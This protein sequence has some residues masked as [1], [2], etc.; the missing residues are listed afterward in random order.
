MNYYVNPLLFGEHADPSI[1]LDGDEYFMVF[2]SC[3]GNN[4]L[5]Q[6]WHSENLIEWTPMYYVLESCGLDNAW[7]PE[8][9][10]Y[11]GIYYIYNYA[12]A[13]GCFVT[14]TSD[15]R[16]GKW[17]QPVIIEGV[18]GIDPGHVIDR[19][20]KRYLI[21]SRNYLYPLS[22]NGLRIIG[23]G[24][25]ICDEWKIPD[26]IDVEGSCAESPKFFYKDGYYYLTIA[27][28]GT[29]GPATSHGSISYRAKELYGPY[30]MSPYTPVIHT[31]SKQEKW[32]SKG[33]STVFRGKDEKWY[34][35]YHA[36]ENA[37]RYAGRCTLLMPVQWD[38]HGWFYV[39]NEDAVE[40]PCEPGIQKHD[41]TE[42]L[43]Y[44]K[45]MKKLSPLFNFCTQDL[46]EQ[47]K[48]TNA[49]LLVPCRG[50][51]TPGLDQMITF[52]HQSH[53]FSMTVVFEND[54]E[55]VISLGFWFREN[56]KCGIYAKGDMI[57]LYKHGHF[58][59]ENE[60]K[61]TG[62][63]KLMLKM[64]SK[65]GTVSYWYKTQKEE[66]WHKMIH[67]YDVSDWNPNVS[68]GFGYARSNVQF[69]G[70][71]TVVITKLRYENLD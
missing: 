17:S 29:E 5:M 59:F 33:H 65:D 11:K 16:Q 30:E 56:L 67:T 28:G 49:G 12:P 41:M 32:W 47:I 63:N 43:Q 35:V 26:Y 4:G 6:M 13:V 50:K 46:F 51:Q 60:N 54:R 44:E 36:I 61:T 52:A 40:I 18:S 38:D 70:K 48:Y 25:K 45:G 68:E 15:I 53:S 21:M 22:E 42:Y 14:W 1:L 19:Q 39:S 66:Q 9:I 8:L 20:G 3:F 55:S 27:Q 71:G 64:V 58:Q 7:A 24:V 69:W 2:S 10:K 23:D 62:T 31:E 57:G 34:M 37:H